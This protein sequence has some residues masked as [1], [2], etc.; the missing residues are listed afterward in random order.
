MK[1]ILLTAFVATLACSSLPTTAQ[2]ILRDRNDNSNQDDS[3]QAERQRQVRA[4]RGE[5]DRAQALIRVATTRVR[6]T[7]KA[8]PELLAAEKELEQATEAFE[9]KRKAIVDKLKQDPAYA[10]A[11]EGESAASADVKEEQQATNE[12]APATTQPQSADEAAANL[13]PPSQEQV[14][15]AMNK[16][17]KRSELRDIEEKAITADPAAREA[18]VKRDA[19]RE[20]VQ[21][22]QLQLDAAMQNDPEFKSAQEQLATARANLA[23]AGASQ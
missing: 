1:R 22:L 13:P 17:N 2:V 14:D 10:K 20:K 15:A 8:N 19:A 7:W 9:V 23:R 12:K 11:L 16:L 6:S 4:A 5:I 18:M 3:R 21:A